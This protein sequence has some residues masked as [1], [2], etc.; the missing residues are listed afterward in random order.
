MIGSGPLPGFCKE[1][2]GYALPDRTQHHASGVI[3]NPLATYLRELRDIRP[4]GA[5]VPE[6]SFYGPLANLLNDIG[7]TLKPRVRC[8]INPKNQGAGIPDG[9]FFTADH[10]PRTGEPDLHAQLT[11]RGVMEVN[12]TSDDAW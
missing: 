5:N 10:L 11:A 9:G 7:R 12:G 2:L 3:L 4:S 1:G 8:I 6:T